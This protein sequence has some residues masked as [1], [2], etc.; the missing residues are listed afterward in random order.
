ME[1]VYFK[2]VKKLK[3]RKEVKI[4]MFWVMCLCLGI[5]LGLRLTQ[6]GI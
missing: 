5:I 4:F 2:K 3:L 6:L 1:Y